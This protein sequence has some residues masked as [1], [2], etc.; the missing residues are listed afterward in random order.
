MEKGIKMG[1]I[2]HFG[3]VQIVFGIGK[4]RE[5]PNIMNFLLG[6]CSSCFEDCPVLDIWEEPLYG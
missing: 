3:N 1:K 6:S 2:M 5:Y 4:S